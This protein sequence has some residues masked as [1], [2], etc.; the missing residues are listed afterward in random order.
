MFFPRYPAYKVRRLVYAAVC[1]AL[2]LVLPLLTGHLRAVGKMLLP[3][4]LPVLLA[5]FIVGPWWALAV[6][7]LAPILRHLFFG[8]P[9]YPSFVAM[10]FE[11]AAYGLFSGLLYK[12]T[13]PRKWAIYVSLLGA[14][15]VGRAISGVTMSMLMGLGDE[16]YTFSAFIAA[17]FTSGIPGIVLQLVLVPLLVMALEKA[18]IIRKELN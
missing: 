15:V 13:P 14:M 9:P 6:G 7:F 2:A 8:M 1:L 16:P 11:L 18:N 12:R 4:H 5:G 10:A 3:M 17:N